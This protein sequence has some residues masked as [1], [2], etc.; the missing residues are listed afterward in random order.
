M[1]INTNFLPNVGTTQNVGIWERLKVIGTRPPIKPEDRVD[2]FQFTL[3]EEKD[4]V[5]T[6]ILNNYLKKALTDGL[7]KVP[8]RMAMAME[9]KRF[10][11]NPVEYFFDKVLT[12]ANQPLTKPLWIKSRALYGE[13]TQFHLNVMKFF[14][15]MLALSESDESNKLLVQKTSETAFS[16]LIGKLGGFKKEYSGHEYWNNLILYSERIWSEN[17]EKVAPE[18]L[19][20][21][22]KSAISNYEQ[23]FTIKRRTDELLTPMV[24]TKALI[25]MAGNPVDHFEENEPIENVT[26]DIRP[27][28]YLVM[29]NQQ[30]L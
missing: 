14:N 29:K 17:G 1:V 23:L 28:L 13:Y 12:V 20:E 30:L 26:F 16:L 10:Q 15:K 5:L 6:Y 7:K 4:E 21:M 2:E 3:A 18:W 22:K 27:L 9:Y 25:D 19:E 8:K 24:Q 11:E